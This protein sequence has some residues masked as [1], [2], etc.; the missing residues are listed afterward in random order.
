MRCSSTD[1]TR[2]ANM[3][4]CTGEEAGRGGGVEPSRPRSRLEEG[5]GFQLEKRKKMIVTREE[6]ATPR[7]GCRSSGISPPP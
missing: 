1:P 6:D 7:G 2:E 3:Q 5:Q 4:A